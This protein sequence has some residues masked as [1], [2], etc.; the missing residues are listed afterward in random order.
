M[1]EYEYILDDGAPETLTIAPIGWDESGLVWERHELYGSVFRAYSTSLKFAIKAGGGGD[2]IIDNYD[3]DGIKAAITITINKRNPQTDAFDLLFLGILDLATTYSRERDLVEVA[4]I[5]G[6][7]ENKFITRDKINYDLNSVISTDGTAID[8]FVDSPVSVEFSEIEFNL[9]IESSGAQNEDAQIITEAEETVQIGYLADTVDLNEID[10]RLK[11]SEDPA[12]LVFYKNTT[13]YDVIVNLTFE[14]S[15]FAATA[16]FVSSGGNMT[17]SIAVV[18]RIRQF[19]N[20]D[21]PVP[22]GDFNLVAGALAVINVPVSPKEETTN[23]FKSGAYTS[24]V[25]EPGGYLQYIYDFT[26]GAIFTNIESVSCEIFS[27]VT[28]FDFTETLQSATSDVDCFMPYEAFTRLIQL[29]TSQTDEAKLLHSNFLGRTDSEFQTYVENGVGANDAITVGWYLRQFTGKPINA[30]MRDLFTDFRNKYNIGL[31]YDRV[32]ER[33]VIENITEFYQSGSLMFDMGNVSDLTVVPY[34]KAYFSKFDTGYKNKVSFEDFN[35]IFEFIAPAEHSSDMPVKD[36]LNIQVPYYGDSVGM[37]LARLRSIDVAISEDTKYDERI[38]IVRTSVA[39]GLHVTDTHTDTVTG[40]DYY[41][42]AL[43][44][45][46]NLIR[47]GGLIN[48]M[49]WK[50]ATF[51][52]LFVQN[53]K[54]FN[55]E[56]VNQNADT[57]NEQDDV[58]HTEFALNKLFNPEVAKFEAFITPAMITQLDTNPHGLVK[59]TFDSVD[60][61]GYIK[62]FRTK[63]YNRQVDIELILTDEFTNNNFVYED[64][65]NFVFENGNNFVLE[66]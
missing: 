29:M 4:I 20:T 1:S 34:D 53:Q 61:Y 27:T 5:D 31:A 43:T 57:V 47:W 32:N 59:A 9:D 36:S 62:S 40:R 38:Y 14:E 66:T 26:S 11:V 25:I 13:K 8:A 15:N 23:S 19:S 45:R 54:D 12:S 63:D 51:D 52:I 10:K 48:A 2:I 21:S 55:L 7:I 39:G 3:T 58:A 17:G 44:P 24:A 28:E 22:G 16:N 42:I 49:M 35:G 41:N 18:I 6:S 37:A 60:Y 50:D 65:D 33:F 56:Y 46:E 30:N 64:A